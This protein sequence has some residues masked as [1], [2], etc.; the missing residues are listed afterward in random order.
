MFNECCRSWNKLPMTDSFID[1]VFYSGFSIWP[2]FTRFLAFLFWL[3]TLV[4]FQRSSWVPLRSSWSKKKL[5]NEESSAIHLKNKDAWLT[6]SRLQFLSSKIFIKGKLG[7]RAPHVASQLTR[8]FI[9]IFG[10]LNWGRS[11]TYNDLDIAKM[12]NP[13]K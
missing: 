3:R 9:L 5:P 7:G 12:Q 13:L 6:K 11:S 1:F 8:P 10:V 2:C 4:L